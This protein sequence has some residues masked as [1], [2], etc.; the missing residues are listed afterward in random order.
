M[1][2]LHEHLIFALKP[3]NLKDLFST[4][5]LWKQEV[6]TNEIKDFKSSQRRVDDLD[7]L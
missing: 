4:E 1:F 5:E 6:S 7:R 3:W 2:L